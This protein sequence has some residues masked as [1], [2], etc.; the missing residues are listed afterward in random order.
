MIK[1]IY[2]INNVQLFHFVRISWN[3]IHNQLLTS[4]GCYHNSLTLFVIAL[5]GDGHSVFSPG[6]EICREKEKEEVVDDDKREGKV[7]RRDK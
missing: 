1:S 5:S 3:F 4:I 2:V 7:R 6:N